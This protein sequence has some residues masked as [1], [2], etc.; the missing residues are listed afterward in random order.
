MFSYKIKLS[1]QSES[2][3]E[4]YVIFSMEELENKIQAEISV[5]S[6]NLKIN[7]DLS[8]RQ[9]KL[10]W[11]FHLIESKKKIQ[12]QNVC[13]ELISR[14][15]A[16]K[17]KCVCI[18]KIPNIQYKLY[19]EKLLKLYKFN[20]IKTIYKDNILNYDHHTVWEKLCR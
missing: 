20:K 18:E 4:R 11:D 8:I 17:H 10:I 15:M 19:I 6:L 13:L 5:L 2:N 3:I 1:Y 9:K 16:S 7:R 12:K 14:I